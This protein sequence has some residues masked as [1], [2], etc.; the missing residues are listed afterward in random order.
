[1]TLSWLRKTV[2]AG[3]GTPYCPGC[4]LTATLE[5]VCAQADGLRSGKKRAQET[6]GGASSFL[7]AEV[8]ELTLPPL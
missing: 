1:M 3:C 4:R 7:R 8:E 2:F 6:L 5:S